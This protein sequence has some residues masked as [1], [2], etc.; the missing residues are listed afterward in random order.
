[1][2]LNT[3]QLQLA[4]SATLPANPGTAKGRLLAR[5]ALK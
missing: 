5:G 2:R 3:S 4:P 1:M